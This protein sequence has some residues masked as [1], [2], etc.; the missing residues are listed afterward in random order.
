MPG[1]TPHGLL[2]PRAGLQRFPV[3]LRAARYID[4]RLLLTIAP[5][6]GSN[7]LQRSLDGAGQ[8]LQIIQELIRADVDRSPAN[9]RF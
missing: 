6:L 7:G 3:S 2:L 4:G 5:I 8:L 9:Q 1:L